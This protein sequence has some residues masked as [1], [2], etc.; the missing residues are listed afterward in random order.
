MMSEPVMIEEIKRKDQEMIA[1][2]KKQIKG[3]WD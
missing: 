2:G 3:R 1:K